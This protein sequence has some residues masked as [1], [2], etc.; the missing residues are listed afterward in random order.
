MNRRAIA[1]A[2]VA[3]VLGGYG[4]IAEAHDRWRQERGHHH[5][6]HHNDHWRGGRVFIAPPIVHYPRYNAPPLVYTPP[7][8]YYR[9]PEY[10]FERPAYYRRPGVTISLPPV[11]IGF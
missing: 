5:R 6:G 4:A 2:L 9:E 7:P 10:Y 11:F 3:I 8:A 1:A